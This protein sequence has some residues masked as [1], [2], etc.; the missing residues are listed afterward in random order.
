MRTSFVSID[1]FYIFLYRG[2]EGK[3]SFQQRGLGEEALLTNSS[4]WHRLMSA[5]DVS[6][7]W[8]GLCSSDP[9]FS[10]KFLHVDPN[11]TSLHRNSQAQGQPIADQVGLESSG[12]AN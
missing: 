12:D 7:L 10:E 8:Y 4:W 11:P 9:A 3:G 1:H 5:P 2:G 6:S